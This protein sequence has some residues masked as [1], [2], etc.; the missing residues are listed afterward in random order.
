MVML[1]PGGALLFFPRWSSEV[2]DL[3]GYAD[4]IAL[5]LGFPAVS[6]SS[7]LQ[8]ALDLETL[9]RLGAVRLPEGTSAEEVLKSV[10]REALVAI[11]G[12]ETA[13]RRQILRDWAAGHVSGGAAS[14]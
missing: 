7:R 9:E 11:L 6:Q 12:V 13:A 8:E 5:G 14:G 3:A 4:E 10:V 2:I 1:R